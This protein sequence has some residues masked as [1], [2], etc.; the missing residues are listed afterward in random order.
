MHII[1]QI[2]N[3]YLLV[4]FVAWEARR[5]SRRRSSDIS[6]RMERVGRSKLD[7]TNLTEP[8]VEVIMNLTH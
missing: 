1:K 5:L 4:K 6:R 7:Q 2:L 8:D 3:F